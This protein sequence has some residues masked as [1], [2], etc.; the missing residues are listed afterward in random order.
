MIHCVVEKAEREKIKDIFVNILQ[1]FHIRDQ[2]TL[3]VIESKC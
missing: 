1:Y 2:E 3:F